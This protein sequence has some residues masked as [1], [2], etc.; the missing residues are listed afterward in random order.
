MLPS[1]RKMQKRSRTI[2]KSRVIWDLTS[3][4]DWPSGGQNSFLGPNYKK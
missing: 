4:S 2:E 3:H 1:R